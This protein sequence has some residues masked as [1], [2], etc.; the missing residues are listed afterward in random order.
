MQNVLI[1]F[2]SFSVLQDS[3]WWNRIARVFKIAFR[4]GMRLKIISHVFTL[5]CILSQFNSYWISWSRRVSFLSPTMSPECYCLSWHVPTVSSFLRGRHN[6]LGLWMV[7]NS[8]FRITSMTRCVRQTQ[9]W[10][11]GRLNVG[12]NCPGFDRLKV[13]KKKPFSISRPVMGAGCSYPT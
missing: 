6:N 11:L 12:D 8:S 2:I 5:H 13:V 3:S 7:N 4:S 1:I 10:L 9:M